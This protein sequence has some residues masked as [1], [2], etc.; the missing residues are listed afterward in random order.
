MNN[1]Y[2]ILT[3]FFAVICIISGLLLIAS[4][5]N[6]YVRDREMQ[7]LAAQHKESLDMPVHSPEPQLEPGDELTVLPE[8][9]SLYLQNTDL[10]GWLSLPGAGIDYPVMYDREESPEY[11]LHRDFDGNY[12]FAG[13]P[14]IGLGADTDSDCLIIH[15]HNMTDKSMFGQL[16][17]YSNEQFYSENPEFSFCTLYARQQYKVFA[18]LHSR[19]LA[20]NEEGF[21]YHKNTGI[22]TENEYTQLVAFLTENS[23]YRSEEIPEYGQQIIILSTCNGWSD[24]GRFIVAA[25]L[26]DD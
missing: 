25:F 17:N 24:E 10:A 22:L 12:S 8:L 19:I 18:A 16:T 23:I 21:H 3:A 13:V 15:G 2:K 1:K 7:E 6:E 5:T 14:F 26:A 9:E 20:E 11:Y 4:M